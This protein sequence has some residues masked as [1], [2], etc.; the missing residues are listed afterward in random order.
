MRTFKG[1]MPTPTCYIIKQSALIYLTFTWAQIGTGGPE[2]LLA[3]A[4]ISLFPMYTSPRKM[5]ILTYVKFFTCM[6]FLCAVVNFSSVISHNIQDMKHMS[7]FKMFYLLLHS[8][9]WVFGV[10]GRR[11]MAGPLFSL[12]TAKK[13]SFFPSIHVLIR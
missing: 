12:A 11:W 10:H 13:Y 2:K 4:K 7:R 5:I 8:K 9:W 6:P 3:T 1:L